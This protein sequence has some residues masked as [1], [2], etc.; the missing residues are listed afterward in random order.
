MTGK[1]ESKNDWIIKWNQ[2]E[3]NGVK[4]KKKTGTWY[5]AKMKKM[6]GTWYGAKMKK[7]TG[8]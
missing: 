3:K 8:K 2:H 1:I 6:T 4:K 5:G 7:M